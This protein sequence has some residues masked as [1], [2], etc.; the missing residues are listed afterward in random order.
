MK[1]IKEIKDG[2]LKRNSSLLK[3]AVKTGY[4]VLKNREDP[5]KLIEELVGVNPD[6]FIDD[7]SHYKGSIMKAGQMISQ[8]GEYYLSP[9]VNEKLKLLHSSTHFIEYKSIKDQLNEQH[10]N[11]LDI[12]ETPLAAASIGQV[13][14]AKFLKNGENVV[15]K[16]Q[17]KGIDNAIKGDMLFLKML[18]N[19][20]KVFP[21]GVD[22][23]DVFNEIKNV[24][25]KE[26][27][28][29]REA[30]MIEE[31][32]DLLDDDFFS[33]PKLYSEYNT[34]KVLCFEKINGYPLSEINNLTITQE[35]KNILGEKIFELFLR[36]VFEFKLIQTD[37]HGGNYFVDESGSEII[38]LDFGAC[39]RFDDELISFYQG[40]L[41]F[42]F[43]AD[44]KNFFKTLEAFMES[45]GKYLEY[46]EEKLWN[47]IQLVSD[48]LRSES[49]DWKTTDIHNTLF[50]E[51]KKLRKSISF[52]S[53][54]AQFIFIDRKVLGVF[55]ILRS[56]GA[57][58]N[59][60]AIFERVLKK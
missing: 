24:L 22:T 18:S 9:E 48:T 56:I 39:L 44:R 28:Y 30:L 7:L 12:V 1:K 47:Y 6:Q 42:S 31:Y 53:I 3:Y 26:M 13:H 34:D 23:T 4:T 46:E 5:K 58:I 40:F 17:Y 52:S 2:L 37:A 25:E 29:K 36:E 55:S 54:P 43:L 19:T 15:L 50:E 27:D 57:Q 8:Y 11:D 45:S 51:G 59:M 16:I 10:I 60:K 32:R 14:E 21:K 49:F 41:K 35:N 20:M 38:L 33:I